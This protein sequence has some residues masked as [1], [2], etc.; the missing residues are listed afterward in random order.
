MKILIAPNAFKESLSAVQIARILGASLEKALPDSIIERVPLADGGDGTLEVLVE[1]WKG[2][3]RTVKTEDP[4]RRPIEAEVGLSADGD[5]AIIEMARISG[6][7][8]LAED[9]KAP[10]KTTTYGLGLAIRE[11]VGWGIDHLY[12]GIGGSATN[13]GGVGMGE[14][15]GYRHLNRAGNPV[16]PVGGRLQDIARIERPSQEIGIE[17][18]QVSVFSDVT[19]PLCGERG[20]SSVFGP[21]KGATPEQVEFLDRGLRRLSEIW[22]RDLGRSVADVPGAG[23][24]GGLGAGAMVY[25]DA[26]IVPGADALLEMT[27]LARRISDC[28]VVITGEGALD[29]STLDG[30]LPSRVARLAKQRGVPCI[31]IYGL[32]DRS[33]EKEFIEAGFTDLIPLANEEIP[34][35]IR[36]REAAKFLKE[37]ATIIAE[38]LL[39]NE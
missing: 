11:I 10:S 25:L 34:L 19:N 3:F 39:R 4:L 38:R 9:E 29:R 21:Q 22:D 18:V 5:S 32:L 36:K 15:L 14:A 24:A 28:D 16:E 2:S 37:S 27:N 33:V 8:L 23:A 12:L 6:L 31:G 35:E 26:E 7:A 17:K 30:K 20:A 13:D 1:L